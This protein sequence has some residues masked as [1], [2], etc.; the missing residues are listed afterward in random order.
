MQSDSSSNIIMN[1]H[2]HIPRL[3]PMRVGFSGAQEKKE[4]LLDELAEK[5]SEA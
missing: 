4:V 3:D 1:V 5:P 2:L